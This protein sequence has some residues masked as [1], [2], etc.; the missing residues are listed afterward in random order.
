MT[1][2]SY[3]KNPLEDLNE[4]DFKDFLIAKDNDFVKV[5][6]N[7]KMVVDHQKW[8]DIHHKLQWYSYFNHKKICNERKVQLSLTSD[9]MNLLIS[10][11]MSTLAIHSETSKI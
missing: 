11:K 3:L 10:E 6:E 8:Y 7:G 5:I 9:I 4:S 2:N 1:M